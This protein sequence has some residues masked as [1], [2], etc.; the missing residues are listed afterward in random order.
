MSAISSVTSS[1]Y[2]SSTAAAEEEAATTSRA[3]L[4]SDDFIS[5]LLEELSSQDPL[6][7]M[8]T[9]E[10]VNQLV[11]IQNIQAS[12]TQTETLTSLSESM[13]D[14][15]TSLS[16]MTFQSQFQAGCS[17][18]GKDVTGTTSDGVAISGTVEK[19]SYSG[20]TVTLELESGLHMPYANVETVA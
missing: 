17:L 12:V 20:T 2:T 7:P 13:E 3:E 15:T 16:G 11:Q 5:L 18:V 6:S 14:I 8:D 10:M 19:A 9:S 4:T 1:L